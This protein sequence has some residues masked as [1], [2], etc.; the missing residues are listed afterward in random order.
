LKKIAILAHA[1]W[2]SIEVEV[3]KSIESNSTLLLDTTKYFKE[4]YSCF[5]NS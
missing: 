2:K 4:N 3:W 1:S 5:W